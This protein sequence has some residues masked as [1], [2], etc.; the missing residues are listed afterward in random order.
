MLSYNT[1]TKLQIL[2]QVFSGWISEKE[3]NTL[4]QWI[5]VYNFLAIYNFTYLYST[6]HSLQVKNNWLILV[7][8]ELFERKIVAH[9]FA[10]LLKEMVLE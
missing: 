5:C 7:S 6:L 4:I 3:S 9:F 1:E 2:W 10:S 8:Q